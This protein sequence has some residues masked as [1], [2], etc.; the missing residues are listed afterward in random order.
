MESVLTGA[1]IGGGISPALC[2]CR[3][4]LKMGDKDP[5]IIV[6]EQ[7]KTNAPVLFSEC[8]SSLQQEALQPLGKST[9]SYEPVRRGKENQDG[10]S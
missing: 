8:L 5:V 4:S 2:L 6:S 9:F 3:D 1:G 10:T 7:G